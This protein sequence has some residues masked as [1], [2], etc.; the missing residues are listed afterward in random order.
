MIISD[1]S[2]GYKHRVVASHLTA[3]LQ[4]GTLTALVGANGMGKST[5][6][7]TLAG[8]QPPLAGTVTLAADGV[9]RQLSELSRRELSRWIGVVLTDRVEVENLT[10]E[11]LVGMGR[12]PYTGFFGR[13][14]RRGR[15]WPQPPGHRRKDPPRPGRSRLLSARCR[16]A[17]G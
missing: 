7:R 5:L 10:V 6:L 17:R 9:E 15:P 8:V 13:P 4:G 16:G 1:L 11:Q 14:N 2:V 12:M 3:R